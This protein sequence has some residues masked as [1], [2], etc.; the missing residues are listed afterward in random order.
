MSRLGYAMHTSRLSQGVSQEFVALQA[1][2][3]CGTYNTLER[4]FSGTGAVANP[5]LATLVGVFTVLDIDLS[6][7]MRSLTEY[8]SR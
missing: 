3:S 2:I 6:E 8:R 5:T 4:G 7:L 1:G